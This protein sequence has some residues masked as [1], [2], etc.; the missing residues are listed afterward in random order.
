MPSAADVVDGDRIEFVLRARPDLVEPLRAALRSD[1]GSN[2]ESRLAALADEPTN[3]AALQL[4]IVAGYYTDKRERLMQL[5]WR[6]QRA[7]RIIL[8]VGLHAGTLTY[9]DAVTFLVEKVK[10]NKPQAE[11][12]VNAYTQSPTYFSTY[13]L[14]MLEIARIREGCRARLGSSF[15]LREFHERFLA[16]GNVPPALI[17]GELDREWK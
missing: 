14:G 15:T 11:G 6:L 4:T 2:L 9:D 8:D 16:F 12:S 10:L 3:L 17:E 13:L 7:A 1:L 5:N